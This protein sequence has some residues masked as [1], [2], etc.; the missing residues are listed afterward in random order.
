MKKLGINLIIGFVLSG[1]LIVLAILFVKPNYYLT[2][3]V[4]D[5]NTKIIYVSKDNKTFSYENDL[6]KYSKRDDKLTIDI[7]LEGEESGRMVYFYKGDEKGRLVMSLENKIFEAKYFENEYNLEGL[8][9]EEMTLYFKYIT[10]LTIT[11]EDVRAQK[12]A[13]CILGVLIAFILSF[14][15]YPAILF[16]NVKE[17]KKLALICIPMTLILCVASAF[18][19]YFT[20]K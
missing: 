12:V 10:L 14:L 1:I 20:L 19:I 6:I 11:H 7:N 17:T 5:S 2:I 15:A 9:P 13:T 4:K 8:T 18:Y 3:L 16:D